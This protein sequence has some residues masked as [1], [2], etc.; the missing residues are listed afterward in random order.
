MYTF[1]NYLIISLQYL[2]FHSFM[3][4]ITPPS[5]FLITKKDYKWIRA[6]K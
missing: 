3:D 2:S 6:M 1:V 4:S 5:P